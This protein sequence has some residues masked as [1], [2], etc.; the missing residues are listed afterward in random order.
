MITDIA[1][2]CDYIYI[3]FPLSGDN[4]IE[5]RMKTGMSAADF[6]RIKKLLEL[7][8]PAIVASEQT[9]SGTAAKQGE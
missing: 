4:A 3:F 2:Y 1:E 6:E 5:L 9:N 7:A 8:K